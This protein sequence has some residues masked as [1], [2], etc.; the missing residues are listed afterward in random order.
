M[1][2]TI[3]SFS[4]KKLESFKMKSST[5]CDPCSVSFIISYKVLKSQPVLSKTSFSKRWTS[6]DCSPDAFKMSSNNSSRIMRNSK[7]VSW[8]RLKQMTRDF[9]KNALM[10]T[11]SVMALLLCNI[12]SFVYASKQAM[13]EYLKNNERSNRLLFC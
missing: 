13:D 7:L 5:P 6:I 2:R 1:E 11:I 10:K 4:S 8:K 9:N 12:V 3:E